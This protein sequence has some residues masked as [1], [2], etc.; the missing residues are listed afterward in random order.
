MSFDWREYLELAE[1]LSER[2]EEACWRSAIS[3][4]YYSAF[5]EFSLLSGLSFRG[6]N[7]HKKLTDEFKNP[8]ESL[9]ENLELPSNQ[10]MTI[11][12]ILNELRMKRNEADYQG[13][14]EITAQ[15]A[16]SAINKVKLS[17]RM[18][19]SIDD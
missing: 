8:D 10:I 1:E 2:S 13:S 19:D 11:G 9:S 6:E 7:S 4:A 18:L 14:V 16:K 3:R 17:F 5:K 15:D 12:S